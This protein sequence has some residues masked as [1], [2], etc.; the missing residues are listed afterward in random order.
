M[1]VL[2][3]LF[4]LKSWAMNIKYFFFLLTFSLYNFTFACENG[5]F[6]ESNQIYFNKEVGFSNN[7][8]FII[9]ELVELY[10]PLLKEQNKKLEIEILWDEPKLN[11]YATRDDD[12]NLLIK[13]SAG[14]LQNEMLSEDGFRLILC[15]ELGHFLGGA[16]KKLRGR[17]TK[18]SWSSAEG[19]ADY[20]AN[21]YCMK[22]LLNQKINKNI[23]ETYLK[24][25][26]KICNSELCKRIAMASIN[27]AKVYAEIDFYNTELSFNQKDHTI[28]YNTI[29]SHP[30]PQCR[31]DTLIAALRCKDSTSL[32][33]NDTDPISGAC[34][35]VDMRRPRCWYYPE[36]D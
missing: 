30:N 13:V 14:L 10:H 24:D 15:H 3:D 29:Y 35:Q 27:V 25:I 9:N 20:Y 1:S 28:V 16:P 17:T 4:L 22:K 23:S 7:A 5:F 2:V 26:D 6:P 32:S 12:N 11:A 19:Q 21:A 33:F 34:Q 8:A 36:I 18:K 31:L